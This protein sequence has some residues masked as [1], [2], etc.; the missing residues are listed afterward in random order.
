MDS[1]VC[2]DC[3]LNVAYLAFVGIL[4]DNYVPF[5]AT[6]PVQDYYDE[7]IWDFGDHD[8]FAW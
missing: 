7:D 5:Q 3:Y 6:P 8:D 1:P 4:D 2:A